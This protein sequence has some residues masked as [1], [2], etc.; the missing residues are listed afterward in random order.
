MPFLAGGELDAGQHCER[1]EIRLH[2]LWLLDSIFC[3]RYMLSV[4]HIM[5]GRE[6]LHPIASAAVQFYKTSLIQCNNAIRVG[7]VHSMKACAIKVRDTRPRLFLP[8]TAPSPT[9]TMGK[10][11]LA[12]PYLRRRIAQGLL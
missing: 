12:A 1:D 8:A 6:Q 5:V 7:G 2:G 9:A 3:C 11:G 10:E 4:P